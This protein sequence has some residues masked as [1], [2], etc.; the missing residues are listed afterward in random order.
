MSHSRASLLAALRAG[1]IDSRNWQSVAAS[2][3]SLHVRISRLREAGF[4]I[5]SEEIDN[6]PTP[7][8]PVRYILRR[9]PC[10]RHCGR[11]A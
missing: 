10:C 3:K 8:P 5:A 1:P 11:P 9:E 6:C 4:E 7:V 2:R